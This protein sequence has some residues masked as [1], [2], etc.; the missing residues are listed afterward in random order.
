MVNDLG[1][2]E[3]LPLTLCAWSGKR[4]SADLRTAISHIYIDSFPASERIDIAAL[5]TGAELGHSLLCTAHQGDSVVGF[6][7][8]APIDETG[9][10]LLGYMAV[11][12]AQRNHGVGSRL[13]AFLAK[14]LASDTAH[15][16][17]LIEVESDQGCPERMRALR[18]RRIRF[19]ERNGAHLVDCIRDYRIPN[20]EDANDEIAM[21]LLW[22]PRKAGRSERLQS[23]LLRECVLTILLRS[24]GLSEDCELIQRVLA[25]IVC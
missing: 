24:Y 22:L 18:E 10:Q 8:S 4:L 6:S 3:D 23:P 13:V 20:L 14:Q 7:Y 2:R 17:I 9:V 11:D 16:G 1:P 15:R 12:A 5:F 25:S 21:K 19:Y